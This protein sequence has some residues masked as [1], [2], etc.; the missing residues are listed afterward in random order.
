MLPASLF[1][2]PVITTFLNSAL[3]GMVLA[4]VTNYYQSLPDVHPA[5]S[6]SYVHKHN[7]S[8]SIA[9][10]LWHSHTVVYV[11]L[12]VYLINRVSVDIY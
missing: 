12:F 4:L 3:L 9:S 2:L 6:E 11:L 10:E 8:S 1:R 7:D 5:D